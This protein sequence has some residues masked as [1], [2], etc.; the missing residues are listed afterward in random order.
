MRSNNS[1]RPDGEREIDDQSTTGFS[2]GQNKLASCGHRSVPNEHQVTAPAMI[3]SYAPQR[4]R[5]MPHFL[6]NKARQ[7]SL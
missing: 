6:L 5:G 1:Q 3:A 4:D 2:P 7:A